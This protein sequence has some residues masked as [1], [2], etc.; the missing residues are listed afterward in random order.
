[1]NEDFRSGKPRAFLRAAVGKIA[2][3]R[4]NRLRW[5]KRAGYR[6]EGKSRHGKIEFIDAVAKSFAGV[7]CEMP[8]PCAG[9]ERALAVGYKRCLDRIQRI[10]Q[11]LVESQIAGDGK[12][13][14]RRGIDA[15]GVRRL[16]PL[17][18]DAAAGVLHKAAG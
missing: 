1:M 7:Q 16:L 13:T 2:R 14:F 11:D 12:P 4:R 8:R 15:M 18:V 5:G 3:Q 9:F 10:D 17:L 6:I